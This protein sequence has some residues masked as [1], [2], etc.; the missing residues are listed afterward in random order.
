MLESSF[1]FIL[2]WHS[3]SFSLHPRSF[4]SLKFNFE[5]I[6]RW[7][8]QIILTGVV[9]MWSNGSIKVI[10]SCAIGL[11]R[12]IYDATLKRETGWLQV[13]NHSVCA[14]IFS[15]LFW[16]SNFHSRSFEPNCFFVHC[17]YEM[18]SRVKSLPEFSLNCPRY[19]LKAVNSTTVDM[20]SLSVQFLTGIW[21]KLMI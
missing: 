6:A 2:P 10:W 16:W 9:E 4:V 21:I 7:C 3:G 8:W 13:I 18:L 17:F 20:V 14:I 1:C 19:V 11:T 15:W 5:W 12:W